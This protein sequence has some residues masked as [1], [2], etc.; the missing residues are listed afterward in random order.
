MSSEQD[1]AAAAEEAR[2]RLYE[3][4]GRVRRS[5]EDMLGEQG[6]EAG[7][8]VRRDVEEMLSG[9]EE[10]GDVDPAIRRELEAL[11]EEARRYAKKRAR[12]AEERLGGRVEDLERR[13]ERLED[14]ERRLDREEQARR[15]AEWRIHTH[16][17]LMLDSLLR[18][19][20]AIA[21]RLASL[22]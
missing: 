18:E 6:G 16:T 10:K 12:K 3:E 22:R 11:R 20:R 14:L 1:P 21:D 2:A 17:E 19:T 5:V 7:S 9:Q 13:L 4:I 8:T 15:H